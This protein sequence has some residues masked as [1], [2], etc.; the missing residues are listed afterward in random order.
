MLR[1]DNKG[2]AMTGHTR[3]FLLALLLAV[4]VIALHFLGRPWI[5]ADGVV[6]LWEGDPFSAR[7]SQELTDWYSF[8]HIIH[9]FI[10]YGLLRW[11]APGLPLATRLLIA[12]AAEAGWEIAENTPVLIRAYHRQVLAEGYAGDSIVNSVADTAMMMLGFLAA[13]R[14]KARYV[15]ALA[16]CFELFTTAMIRDGLTLNVL[17]FVAPMK[18]VRDWQAGARP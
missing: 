14:L 12:L 5:A 8:S 6:R 17:N 18:A 10:F 15:V 7:V 13:A 2:R 3:L 4:Q 16:V 11:L 1:G 9:G